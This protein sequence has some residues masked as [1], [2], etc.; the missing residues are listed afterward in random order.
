MKFPRASPWKT[1]PIELNSEPPEFLPY[2]VRI[3]A[4]LCA[5]DVDLLENLITIPSDAATAD[6]SVR[7][8]S[9]PFFTLSY[10]FV[11]LFKILNLPF[12]VREIYR[13]L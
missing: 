10:C 4:D 5:A 9:E 2:K 6:Q 12:C 11:S 7:T 13:N 8:S 1:K 3:S